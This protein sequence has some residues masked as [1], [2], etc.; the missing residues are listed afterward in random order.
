MDDAVLWARYRR[1]QAATYRALLG[2]ANGGTTVDLGD[3]VQAAVCPVRPGMSLLNAVTYTDPAALIARYE[4]A[5][6][7]YADAGVSAWTVWTDPRDA[8]LVSFLEERGHVLDGTPPAMAQVLAR[9]D[10]AEP[11]GAAAPMIDELPAGADAARIVDAAFGVPPPAGFAAVIGHLPAPGAFHLHVARVDGEPAASLCVCDADGDAYV[12]LVATLP[13]FQ[14]RGLSSALMRHALRAAAARG[15]ET[16]SLEA[17]A[18][19]APVYA[20]LGYRTLGPMQ[21]RERRAG[22]PGAVSPS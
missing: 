17:S 15:C 6:A 12:L 11:P 22:V 20:R 16:T 7:A 13:D 5:A 21:M 10:L 18:A 1:S 8:G 9:M 19:G 4:A 3:G 2:P 14:R